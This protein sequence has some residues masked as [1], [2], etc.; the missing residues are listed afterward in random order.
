MRDDSKVIR[1]PAAPKASSGAPMFHRWPVHVSADVSLTD[2]IAA[3]KIGGLLVYTDRV[4]GSLFV[5]R[6]CGPE[7]A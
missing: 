1:F 5:Q 7:A 2:F 3:L 6:S 4:T